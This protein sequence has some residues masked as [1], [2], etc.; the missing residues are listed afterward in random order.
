MARK[1]TEHT[2]PSRHGGIGD[3][4]QSPELGTIASADSSR[5]AYI[6]RTMRGQTLPGVGRIRYAPSD[7]T[8][9]PVGTTVVI[10]YDL[11]LPV[12]DGVLDVPATPPEGAGI[13]ATGV[14]GFG[15]Q[16]TDFQT[17]SFRGPNEPSDLLPGDTLIGNDSGARVGVL[18]G[19]VGI[20]RGSGAAQIRA[21]VLHDL[22]EI[23]S[24]NFRHVTD[25]GVQEIR[26]TDGRINMSFRGASDQTNE[27]GADEENWTVKFDLGSEGDMLNFELC[28]PQG[29]TLFKFHVDSN[30]RAELFG[31]DGVVIQSGNR[32]GEAQI[33][34][35]GGD[36]QDIVHGDREVVTDGL[37]T[38]TT[39]GTHAHTVDGA[40]SLVIGND[41]SAVA[42]RD[43]GVSSGR[44]MSLTAAGDKLGA[45]ALNVTAAGGNYETTVGQALYPT[46]KYALT[47]YKG[48]MEFKSSL[49]GNFMVDSLLGD[50]KSNTRKVL[51]NTL[52]PDSVILGG[53]ALVAHV[54]RYE[55]LKV[56]I[57]TMAKIFD[58]HVHPHPVAPTGVPT[59]PMASLIR[60]L[61]LACKSLRVG[62]GG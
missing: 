18:Q 38:E 24:R 54:V 1:N 14:A 60:A 44:N 30:G 57:D 48:N 15:T 43:V 8:I 45:V 59:V 31:L 47:T 6:V 56:L 41:Y 26:N 7:L 4:A 27:A 42:V 51:M 2:G 19:G 50:F 28:T 5:M 20:L 34:E 58:T 61:I 55:Q 37:L 53:N 33:S 22:V 3:A 9:L 23:I 17:G 16:T 11:G 32:N 49:G 35:Q 10:R 25:M 40:Y 62:V 12:I 46:P 21:H 39:Q 52:T 29:Q 36:A 13:T